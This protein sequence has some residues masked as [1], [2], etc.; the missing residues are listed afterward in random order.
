MDSLPKLI[1]QYPELLVVSKPSLKNAI[2]YNEERYNPHFIESLISIYKFYFE[3]DPLLVI[4]KYFES[5]HPGAFLADLESLE[6]IKESKI[7]IFA[8]ADILFNDILKINKRR[9]NTIIKNCSKKAK[10]IILSITTLKSLELPILETFHLQKIY[11]QKI[12]LKSNQIKSL[13]K[14]LNLSLFDLI[15]SDSDT[16]KS[17]VDS[18]VEMLES[19]KDKRIYISLSLPINKI[20]YIETKLKEFY[21]VYRKEQ[22]EQN[23][24]VINSC[25]TTQKTLLKHDYDIY[26]FVLPNDLEYLD[27]LYY[28]KDIFSDKEKEIYIDSSNNDNVEESLMKL[29]K[30]SFD[31]LNSRDCKEEYDT[32]DAIK[33]EDKENAILAT[34]EYFRFESPE[35]IQNMDL[36][37]LSKKDY[38]IIRNYIKLR[39]TCKFDLNV[40]TCQLSTPCSPKDRSRKLNSLSNKISS[41]DYRCDVTCEIF[42]DYTIGVI[43]WNETFSSKEKLNVLKNEVYI[44][45]TTS[46]KWKHTS[47]Y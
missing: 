26:I 10:V 9:L 37:N 3:I 39:L 29:Y 30:E 22:D 12:Q 35:S 24:I 18:L 7:I 41:V 20:L 5:Y 31:K 28:F 40:K 46:G 1:N 47:I 21:Q 36:R 2:F 34:D 17:N 6:N 23:G 13:N 25:K 4:P 8:Y 32:F 42:K 19:F 16:F 14:N 33:L 15:D 38:D 27:I 43:I 11:L 44:Y 45:Q